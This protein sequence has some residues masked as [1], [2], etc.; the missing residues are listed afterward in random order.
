MTRRFTL[1]LYRMASG[2]HSV[3]KKIKIGMGFDYKKRRKSIPKLKIGKTKCH[4]SE[5]AH[6]KF[7]LIQKSMNLVVAKREAAS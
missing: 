2:T 3:C 1:N 5:K 6:S 7:K 4:F